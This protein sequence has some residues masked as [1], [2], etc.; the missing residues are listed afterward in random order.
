MVLSQIIVHSQAQTAY[1]EVCTFVNHKC[2]FIV[3]AHTV[4]THVLV[5]LTEMF[6]FDCTR[7]A[8]PSHHQ[9]GVEEGYGRFSGWLSKGIFKHL[10]ITDMRLLLLLKRIQFLFVGRHRTYNPLSSCYPLHKPEFC[11]YTNFMVPIHRLLWVA[12][13]KQ[14]LKY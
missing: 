5:F 1:T 13:K 4:C 11:K 7:E 8:F 10:G 6:C 14:G 12:I 9:S 3:K 2:C